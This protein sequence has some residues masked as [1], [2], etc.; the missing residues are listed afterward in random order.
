M[1]KMGN[2]SKL[3]EK[4]IHPA[5]VH[6]YRKYPFNILLTRILI[7]AII[8]INFIICSKP[9][10]KVQN[11]PTSEFYIKYYF[12]AECAHHK[13]IIN[14]S[15]LIY[16]YFEDVTGKCKCWVANIAC[17]TEEELKTKETILPNDEINNLINLIKQTNFM[18]L[19]TSIGRTDRWGRYYP[20]ELS[21]KIGRKDKRVIYYSGSSPYPMP[22][23]FKK[24]KEKLFE[25]VKEKLE[26]KID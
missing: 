25:L 2:D 13:I 9:K 17:W 8:T 16:T 20:Y 26:L 11:Q 18:S 12:T 1:N 5:V 21:V 19:D 23:A 22:E 3:I 14:Q 15:K 24:I 6:Q 10:Q 4:I 7:L